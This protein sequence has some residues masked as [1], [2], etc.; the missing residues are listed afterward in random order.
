MPASAYRMGQI[1]HDPR[2]MGVCALVSMACHLV[3]FGLFVFQPDY[4]SRRTFRPS[5]IDVSI[6]TLPSPTVENESNVTGEKREVVTKIGADPATP[7]PKATG[8]D[9][10]A[11]SAKTVST[12]SQAFRPK[13]SLKKKTFRSSHVLKRAISEIEKKVDTARADPVTKAID[14]LRKT[15]DETDRTEGSA[16]GADPAVK[17]KGQ[18]KQVLELMD[19]YKAEIPYRIQKNWVF[20]EQ[21]AEGRT[22]LVAWLVIEIMP[23]GQIGNIWFEKRSGNRYFDDQAY[24]AVKKSDPLP[25]LPEGYSRPFFNVGLRF[26]PLGLK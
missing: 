15:I 5:V 17:P 22:D 24:K 4:P 25:S 23:E 11:L 20:S 8:S 9:R 16:S 3:L 10:G 19:I 13:T 6:V 7:T 12:A 26:T 14:R 1:G 21:L 18:S 2:V